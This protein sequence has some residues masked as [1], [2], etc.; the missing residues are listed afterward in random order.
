MLLMRGTQ[1]SLS[2][3]L[4]ARVPWP[5]KHRR[6]QKDGKMMERTTRPEEK[7]TQ[8]ENERERRRGRCK[9]WPSL[10]LHLSMFMQMLMYRARKAESKQKNLGRMFT[11]IF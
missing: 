3:L 5:Q 6:P 10:G 4:W 7:E 1:L 9:D 8:T 2:V 11:S